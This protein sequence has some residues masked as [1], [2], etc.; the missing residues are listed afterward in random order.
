VRKRSK[1]IRGSRSRRRGLSKRNSSSS[2]PFPPFLCFPHLMILW[3][4]SR[5]FFRMILTTTLFQPN[6][7]FLLSFSSSFDPCQSNSFPKGNPITFS[8]FIILYTH[9]SII[10]QT[11]HPTSIQHQ[12]PQP[13]KPSQQ[14]FHIYQPNITSRQIQ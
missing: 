5:V 14:T 9:P 11:T 6:L 2:Q 1:G 12:I 3:W 4:W 13:Q 7:H 10:R 8:L